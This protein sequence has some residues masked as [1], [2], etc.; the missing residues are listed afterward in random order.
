MIKAQFSTS[1]GSIVSSG[2]QTGYYTED[3]MPDETT[4]ALLS[5]D[6]DPYAQLAQQAADEA[7]QAAA[8]TDPAA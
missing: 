1:T 2:G 8:A 6:A 5:E 7:A 3:N 4:G